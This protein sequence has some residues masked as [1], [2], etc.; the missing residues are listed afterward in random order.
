LYKAIHQVPESFG[1]SKYEFSNLDLLELNH[2]E[3]L[4]K[5]IENKVEEE[6]MEKK[7]IENPIKNETIQNDPI[8]TDPIQKDPIQNDPIQK[9][10]NIPSNPPQSPKLKSPIKSPNI[11]PIIPSSKEDYCNNEMFSEVNP[12]KTE[13]KKIELEKNK[14]RKIQDLK[15]LILKKKE[16]ISE[17]TK[18]TE[19]INYLKNTTNSD[20]TFEELDDLDS[21]ELNE[22]WDLIN[23]IKNDTKLDFSYW[24]IKGIFF[25]IEYVCINFLNFTIFKGL[26]AK[27]TIDVVK[28]DLYTTH[29]YMQSYIECPDYPFTDII[30]YLL[31]FIFM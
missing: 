3:Q 19:I 23:K 21:D 8:Q 5:D 17:V 7:N 26:T 24:I 10:D 4:D 1:I 9:I 2:D 28:K 29:N 20:Y 12:I 22:L 14:R 18:K 30:N 13:K 6:L 11:A 15:S 16:I 25:I 27:I 31:K